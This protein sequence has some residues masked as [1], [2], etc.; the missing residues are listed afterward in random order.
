MNI[1]EFLND[2]KTLKKVMDWSD[3]QPL[4]HVFHSDGRNQV[5]QIVEPPAGAVPFAVEGALKQAVRMNGPVTEVF[6]LTDAYRRVIA[7]DAPEAVRRPAAGAFQDQ[8]RAG[9]RDGMSEC[10]M[11]V[12][13]S[14]EGGEMLM[15]DYDT[16]TRSWA[17]PFRSDNPLGD[18]PAAV[19]AA[20]GW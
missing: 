17:P 1:E 18:I 15:Q 11:A 12:R 13:M 5:I 6:I 9:Q 16:P 14:P 20:L 7:P 3:L 19:K 8:W 4:L 2:C 10:L